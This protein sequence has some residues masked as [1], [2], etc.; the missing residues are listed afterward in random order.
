VR[1]TGLESIWDVSDPLVAQI[2]I[3]QQSNNPIDIST[4][5]QILDQFSVR[6][7]DRF[8]RSMNMF[9]SDIGFEL[10]P[11]EDKEPHQI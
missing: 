5:V 1:L 4:S 8:I 11:E 7:T 9:L 10:D 6:T 3:E 2:D